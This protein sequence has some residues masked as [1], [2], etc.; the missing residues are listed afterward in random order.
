[1]MDIRKKLM[2]GEKIPQCDVCNDSLLSN[3]TYRQWFTGFLFNDKID[4]CFEETDENGYTTMEIT[5]II[6]LVIYCNFKCL[7]CGEQPKRNWETEKR[8]HDLVQRTAILW[9]ENK[10]ITSKRSQKK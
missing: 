7:M 9:S 6:G 5:L 3:S 4:Q 10:K 1:M 2:A 8:K